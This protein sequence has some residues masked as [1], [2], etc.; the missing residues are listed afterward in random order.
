MIRGSMN[1]LTKISLAV[2]M[3]QGELVRAGGG[4]E[5]Y[6]KGNLD[7]E[8]ANTAPSEKNPPLLRRSSPVLQPSRGADNKHNPK[9]QATHAA[10]ED[11]HA[12]ALTINLLTTHVKRNKGQL[13]GLSG[14]SL[15]QA[16]TATSFNQ[17]QL[18]AAQ[19]RL[20]KVTHAVHANM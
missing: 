16:Q 4:T 8:W 10:C 18:A 11:A 5:E 13:A 1:R 12:L 19:Q 15:R 7:S 3:L 6:I 9:E 17:G 14:E 20:A 2:L